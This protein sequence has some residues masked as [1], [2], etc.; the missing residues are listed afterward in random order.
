MEKFG[1]YQILQALG[2]L[3]AA[4]TEKE[5]ALPIQSQGF[6]GESPTQSNQTEKST[7]N[8]QSCLPPPSYFNQRLL[9]IMNRHDEVSRR[10]DQKH[11]KGV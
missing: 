11:G 8:A 7:Q 2:G 1:I 6:Q 5:Q 4:Q 9:E 10:I 3:S